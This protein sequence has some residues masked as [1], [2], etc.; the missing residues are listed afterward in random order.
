MRS[1]LIFF[2]AVRLL[3]SMGIAGTAF[4]DEGPTQ[5]SLKSSDPRMSI[6][7]KVTDTDGVGIPGVQ[8]K[9][10]SPQLWSKRLITITIHITNSRGDYHFYDLPPGEYT[11][12]FTLEGYISEK[13][14][15]IMIS[16]GKTST[17]DVI[18]SYKKFYGSPFVERPPFFD[19]GNTIGK[20]AMKSYHLEALPVK[21]RNFMSF[22]N[23]APGITTDFAH[24]S[25]RMDNS[26]Q[27]DDLEITD[28]V[29]GNNNVDFGLDMVEQV[30]VLAGGL[31]AKYGYVKGAVVK[32]VSGSRRFNSLHG[33]AR[34]YFDNKN[35]Q[36][37]NTRGT[38]LY[39]PNDTP[40]KTGQKYRLETAFTLGGV[41]GKTGI[42]FF[43]HLDFTKKERY[44]PGYP[45]DQ[46]QGE[47]D[48]PGVEQGWLN[49][50]KLGFLS[51]SYRDGLVL[52]YK[53]A[54]RRDHH[55]GANRYYNVDTTLNR[56]TPAHVINLLWSHFFT[57]QLLANF[58]LGFIRNKE[59]L[60]ARRP[61]V[62]YMDLSTSFHTGSY[63][64]NREDTIRDR[65]QVNV[66]TSIFPDG[67]LGRHNLDIGTGFR[68]ANAT[69]VIE[70]FSHPLNGV[71]LAV[72]APEM[73]GEPG[74][75]YGIN[76]NGGMR[77]KEQLL[78]LSAYVQDT[79]RFNNRITLNVGV[80]LDYQALIRPR[81][82]LDRS[83]IP[84]P[85]AAPVDQS[86][87]ETRAPVKWL[88]LSPRLGFIYDVFG[89]GR[90]LVKS[91]WC[92]YTHP[93][94]M[95][96]LD[97][98]HPAG[99]FAYLV[100]LDH[101]S[102]EPVGYSPFWG[103][104]AEVGIGYGDKVL[105]APYMYEI[106]LGFQREISEDWSV[107]IRYI[108]KWDRNLIHTVDASRLDMEALFEHGRL[109]WSGYQPLSLWDPYSQQYVVF[110]NDLAPNRLVQQYIVN[111]PG[112]CRDYDSVELTLNK[113]YSNMHFINISYV[114][115]K[116]RG[117]I[118]LGQSSEL[119]GVS[120]LYNDPN[121]H[122]NAEGRLPGE[123]RHQLK[124][125]GSL[126]LGRWGGPWSIEISGYYRFLSGGRWTRQVTSDYLGGFGI[127]NQG[128]RTI[129]A[130]PKG[131]RGY[132]AVHLLDL[133]VAKPFKMGNVD[134]VLF[135][136]IFNLFNTK[137]AV[138]VEENS[139]RPGNDFLRTLDILEPRQVRLGLNIQFR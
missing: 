44:I 109:Q 20:T 91:S 52:S 128:G 29:T 28:P 49:F 63:W 101:D 40:E 9:L 136:D 100:W 137:T 15:G 58:K 118:G 80:R 89:D 110:Y 17:I 105:K 41:I 130:E 82:A 34:L 96:W 107:G 87:P 95:I 33:A 32:V 45:H 111:P 113:Q 57:E 48:I 31:P 64:K 123:R 13:R 121:A 129:Y 116:A 67:W 85:F 53:Y 61:G 134:L 92:R 1:I 79:I 7:G 65:F 46:M 25:S 4:H 115:Q 42:W 21:N 69:Q 138:Q 72:M 83:S 106:T 14:S 97:P 88:D 27:L 56:S 112:A 38:D 139:S 47:D 93:L 133:R 3:A 103:P 78:N 11:L 19:S 35:L 22:F 2:L 10:E 68:F 76:F 122:I 30:T 94:R 26:Y 114:Y 117:L 126:S 24:G 120:N 39:N 84:N 36:A 127:L 62:D 16:R 12:T 66:D 90:T 98:S 74:W 81:Q 73:F 104:G 86:V 54:E 125:I 131:S 50:F 8:I 77:Q 43:D 108:K 51:P 71:G 124:I 37:D 119:L 60:H 75:Y 132:P 135:A 6:Q 102:G 70:T 99:T 18:L 5:K 55:W 23:L 59:I